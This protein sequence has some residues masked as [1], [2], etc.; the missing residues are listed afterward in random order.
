MKDIDD[1]R[2]SAQRALWGAVPRSLRAFSAEVN[3]YVIR[4]RSV[5]DETATDEDRELLSIVGTEIIADYSSAF[6]ITE[7]FL[8]V[9][10]SQAIQ[11]LEILIYLRHEP[12]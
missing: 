6:T 3:D 5:F 8:T 1:I 4:V 12:R 10:A 2:L 9:P 7:E 11:H